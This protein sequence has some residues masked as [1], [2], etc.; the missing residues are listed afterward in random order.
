MREA[1]FI[2][3]N[4]ERWERISQQPSPDTDEMASEFTQ[5]VE[6]LGYAKSYYPYSKVTRFLNAE[7]SKRYLSIYKN[8]REETNRFVTFFKYDLPLTIA[9]HQLVLLICF[10]LFMIFLFVGFFSAKADESF[11]R[12]MLG[13]F[14]VNTTEQNIESG[15]PFGIYQTGNSF[16]MWIGI[17]INNVSVAFRYFG[18]GIFLGVLS[19]KDMVE[20]G[21]RLGAFEYMFF[22][23]GYGG[24]SILTVMLHGTLE[25]SAIIIAAATGVIIGKSWL[26][27]GTLKR[28]T[29]LKNGAKDG[30]KIIIGLVPVFMIAAFV[31]GFVTRYYRMPAALSISILIL[32]LVFIV[33]YFVIYPVRL[34]K[35]LTRAAKIK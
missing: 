29:A 28:I 15:N 35:S 27:P 34:Q 19:V 2:K 18:E 23:K 25:L 24:L 13:D 8:R 12:N 10:L 30:I 1:L 6:D 14:Y 32:S 5:L 26:F 16:L 21:I 20:E 4:K 33:G 11:V 17:M 9:R 7:A 3:K 22:S 31:E